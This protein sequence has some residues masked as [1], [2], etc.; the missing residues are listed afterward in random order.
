MK[1][2]NR[3]RELESLEKAWQRQGSD[4]VVVSGRRRV[5][6]SRLIEEF[7]KGKN[8]I[9][10]FIVPKEEKQV[11]KDLEDEIRLKSGYSPSFNS[12]RDAME[13]LFEHNAE[14]VIF[15]EFS[16]VLEVNAAIPHEL[17]RL[18]D[19]YKDSKDTL[20]VLSGSYVGLMNRLFAA[21]KAPLFNRATSTISLQ[22]LS[23]KTVATILNEFG[24]TVPSEQ[25]SFFCLFGGIPYY[26]M[27]LEK[28][29]HRSFEKVVN[30][31]FFDVGA[32]L[33]EEGE[34]IL[35]QEFGN[36]YAKYYAILEAIHAGHVSMNKISQEVGI[37]STTLAKYMKS[38]QHDFKIVGRIVP[39]GENPLRSKKGLYVIEDNM[40][41]F[42]FSAVYGKR[43]PP[44]KDEYSFFISRRFEMLCNDFLVEFLEKRG[45]RVLKTG[46][47]WG[48]V[49]VKKGD[50]EQRDIDV[51]VE[52][53]KALY[54]G[55]CKW[56]E[57]KVGASELKLLET[58]AKV[59]AKTK[60]TLKFVLFAKN[61]FTLEESEDILL[62]DAGRI[63]K[64]S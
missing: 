22:P 60:K 20:L 37:R 7:A 29:E 3:E 10:V 58:S 28:N 6:K 40:L 11:A 38:L 41:A 23:F 45:E 61:G 48:S 14:L 56:T 50:S 19:K 46:K 12:F 57:K 39:F 34:N 17:Q 15:D 33:R 36:A 2:Y 25:I 18:W 47:W 52:T 59:V 43:S 32:Q 8:G 24:V 30:S 13:Y 21:K 53:D 16:N 5:G 51:V 1:F 26:Y 27:L 64:E 62:F 4:F 44:T 31:L 55:E 42:W 9:N 49:E 63:V 35:R 54:A